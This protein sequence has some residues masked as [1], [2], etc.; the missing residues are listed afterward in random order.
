[1]KKKKTGHHVNG[2]NHDSVFLLPPPT[3]ERVLKSTLLG[4]RSAS[5]DKRLSFNGTGTSST[6]TLRL[7]PLFP[8]SRTTTSGVSGEV[9]RSPLPHSRPRTTQ[10]FL[11]PCHQIFLGP[12]PSLTS[13]QVVLKTLSAK[14]EEDGLR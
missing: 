11:P 4:H 8:S 3:T 1:M 6:S 12:P 2:P 9:G 10:V 14:T 13:P 7:L 5:E